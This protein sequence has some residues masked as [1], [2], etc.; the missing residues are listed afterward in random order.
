MLCTKSQGLEYCGDDSLTWG[1]LDHSHCKES[2]MSV[3]AKIQCHIKQSNEFAQISNVKN[4]RLLYR[5]GKVASLSCQLNQR[6]DKTL[7]C[8]MKLLIKI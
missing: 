3:S 8:N 5:Q 2:Y 7:F 6:K 1:C 4:G